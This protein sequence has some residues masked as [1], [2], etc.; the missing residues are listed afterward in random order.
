MPRGSNTDGPGPGQTHRHRPSVDQP[1]GTPG[2]LAWAPYVDPAAP[3]PLPLRVKTPEHRRGRA[4]PASTPGYRRRRRSA[5][6]PARELPLRLPLRV[7]PGA[8]PR[9]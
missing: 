6:A 8:P 2:T 5:L 3:P 9:G 7:N 1:R 4:A